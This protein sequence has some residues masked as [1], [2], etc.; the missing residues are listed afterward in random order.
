MA[1][2]AE[3][4]A[5]AQGVT[6]PLR[7]TDGITRGELAGILSHA[8]HDAHDQVLMNASSPLFS[9]RTRAAQMQAAMQGL[10]SLSNSMWGQ[11]GGLT[12]SGIYGAAELAA[13][14][15]VDREYLMGMPFN[16][17]RQYEQGLFFNAYQ[18]AEDI[19]SRRTSGFSLAERIYRNG[20]TTV[21]QVGRIVENGLAQ[22]LSAR[23][24]A[25]R[26]RSYYRPDVPGGSSYA[27]MRLART[28]INNAHH[29]T[30]LRL[31]K[32][33]PWVTGYKW[34]LSGSHPRPD[35]CN[36][37]AD[38]DHIG[39]GSGVFGKADV[40]SKPHPQCLCYVTVQQLD[41][42]EFIRGLT[43]GN[44]DDRLRSMNVRC[45]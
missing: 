13:N 35:I 30:T 2:P 23:E 39:R 43:T 32:D 10:G 20:R 25:A 40:P 31:S 41:R 27:A 26:V 4:L 16:A 3:Q 17:I 33:H 12:R 19:I 11:V 45:A 36:E 28:E 29:D 5:Y 9:R 6:Q 24:L 18:S 34:N 15:Q 37:Y 21:L 7:L 38:D 14:Q 22:Q 42:D 8:A 1:I 44:Y